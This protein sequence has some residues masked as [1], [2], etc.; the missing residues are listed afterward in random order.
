[1]CAKKYV[2]LVFACRSNT[3]ECGAATTQAAVIVHQAGGM[4][5]LASRN[6]QSRV[7]A[8]A[9]G[10]LAVASRDIAYN[11]AHG[12]TSLAATGRLV[13]TGSQLTARNLNEN[14]VYATSWTREIRSEV[15]TNCDHT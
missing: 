7:Q 8:R 15:R 5:T 9:V 6:G 4:S 1:M 3:S 11:Q 2:Y 14:N 10:L 12:Q 13:F